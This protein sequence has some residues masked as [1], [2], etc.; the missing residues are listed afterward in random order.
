M[1]GVPYINLQYFFCLI[2]TIFGGECAKD[3]PDVSVDTS[4]IGAAI[5]T[6]TSTV[7]SGA[8]G[9]G[10][11]A[12]GFWSW[13]WPFG[14]WGGSSDIVVSTTTGIV[15]EGPSLV[16]SVFTSLPVGVQ[17]ALV[18]LGVGLST[19]WSLFSWVSYS[20][21]GILAMAILS[22]VF[23]LVFI[24]MK[25]WGKYGVLPP[26][27]AT[28]SYGWSRWQDLLNET[29]STDPKKWRLA[30]LAADGMLGELLTRLGF[31]GET[32]GDQLRGVPDDAF[33]TVPQAWEAH[34]IKNFV[35]ARNSNFVLTQREAFRVMKLYEQVFE[36]FDFI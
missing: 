16:T 15:E 17:S 36:E 27:D 34:R 2:V 20:L 28:K 33:V 7:V 21:S 22:A 3:V 19:I 14:S 10:E 11:S 35:T 12:G 31:H 1:A 26:R 9:A 6:A 8:Q 30:I 25:E 5:Q 4:G 23:G 32:T 18:A 24:R 29:M 13:L